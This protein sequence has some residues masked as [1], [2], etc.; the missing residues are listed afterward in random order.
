[1]ERFNDSFKH[2]KIYKDLYGKPFKRDWVAKAVFLLASNFRRPFQSLH[3]RYTAENFRVT[4]FEYALSAR[5]NKIFQ[6]R[7]VFVLSEICS[8][9]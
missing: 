2:F 8:R 7:T 3:L 6:K 1:M 4:E 9:Y 5:A